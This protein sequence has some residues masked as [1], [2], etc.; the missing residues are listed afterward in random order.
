MLSSPEQGAP[1]KE[2][3]AMN[4][5]SPWRVRVTGPLQA[6]AAGFREELSGLGYSERS[7]A[8]HLQLMTHLSR[9][10]A[11][12]GSAPGELQVAQVEQFLQARRAGSRVHRNLT[13]RGMGPLLDHLRKAGAVPMAGSA[14]QP[15]GRELAIAQF[16]E[17][18]TL[19]RRLAEPTIANYRGVAGRFLAG[20]GWVPGDLSSLSGES[21]NAF[22]LSEAARR[23]SGSLN[24]V[25][26]AL[27]ALLRFLYLHDHIPVLLADTVPAAPSWRDRGAVRAVTADQVA[28]MLAA[29]DRRTG[30]GRRD[31]AVLKLLARLGLRRGEVASL[32]V[33][34]INW[35]T[36]VLTVTGKGSRREVLPLPVDVGEAIA[37]YCHDG[38]RKG[39]SR[40][41][42]LSSLA[43][44]D[45][46]SPSG[47]G[48]VVARACERAGLPVVG[49]HRLRHTAATEMRAAGAPLSEIGQVL[50]HRHPA[51]TA[52]YAR[53]DMTA[54]LAVARPWP[55][56]QR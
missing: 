55:G 52:L 46:L 56:S 20:C 33:G 1:V 47:V 14:P 23:S 34:D 28:L 44:W 31:Y 27:R 39:G 42:F 43:P 6:Y 18:L 25:T 22:V 36:G 10:L 17:Y 41:L 15:E 48:Q 4:R 9:W 7:C 53:D 54:L 12:T 2:A 49:A 16:V 30:T 8:G 11:E 24:T 37:G 21:V 26:T 35:R 32:S 19:E 51:T 45:G 50:R 38:R 13:L 5:P 3:W 40:S 29:C